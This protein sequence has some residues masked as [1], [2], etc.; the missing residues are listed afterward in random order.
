[1]SFLDA[2]SNAKNYNSKYK[3]I[4]NNLTVLEKF[5]KLIK[6]FLLKKNYF[7][8]RLVTNNH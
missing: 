3:F 2:I 1:M 4:I 7:I 8:E 5:A 6:K